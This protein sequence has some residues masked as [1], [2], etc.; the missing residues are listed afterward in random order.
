M[1]IKGV[2]YD[3]GRAYGG[4]FLTRPVFDPVTTRRELQIIRDDLHA[5]A[6]RFQG[7]DI[8]RLITAAA[9]A[10]ALGLPALGTQAGLRCRRQLLRRPPV[11]A[12]PPRP[13]APS[14]LTSN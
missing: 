2:C 3:V 5:N 10:L 4:R 7:R 13:T 11:I 12:G 1:D 6:V 14:T 8:T 9:G